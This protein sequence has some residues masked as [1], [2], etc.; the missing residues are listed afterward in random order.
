MF[1]EVTDHSYRSYYAYAYAYAD[2]D[3]RSWAKEI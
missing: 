1:L 2:I 3:R